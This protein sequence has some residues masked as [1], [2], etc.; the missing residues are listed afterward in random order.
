MGL[1]KDRCSYPTPDRKRFRA[2][3]FELTPVLS[4]HGRA[5]L[6][7]VPIPGELER[8]PSW[9]G[10][11]HVLDMPMGGA[12]AWV[13][14]VN[15]FVVVHLSSAALPDDPTA[16]RRAVPEGADLVLSSIALRDRTPGFARRLISA[17]RPRL[18]IPHHH[19]PLFG[20]LEDPLPRRS[21]LDAEAFARE[22]RGATV[23]L[24]VP[25]EEMRFTRA[26]LQSMP[27]ARIGD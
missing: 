8:P 11:P 17:L 10:A 18:I 26:E 9:R 3:A 27:R 19:D 13:I 5:P 15:G 24:P 25:F 22:A 2:G 12:I 21:V 14:R 23:R 4:K 1:P 20:A 6:I 16:L 7:G